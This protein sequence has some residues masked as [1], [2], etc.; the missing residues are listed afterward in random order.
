MRSKKNIVLH[1]L[2]KEEKR[3]DGRRRRRRRRR[4]TRK[5]SHQHITGS[6]FKGLI[7]S[8]T[9]SKR[10]TRDRQHLF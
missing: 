2:L 5:R 7:S 9:T 6:E 8:S 3:R 4:R 10:M 1:R